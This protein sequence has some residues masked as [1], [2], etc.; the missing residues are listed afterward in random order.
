MKEIDL[1]TTTERRFEIGA[2]EGA[3]PRLDHHEI[4]ILRSDIWMKRRAMGAERQCPGLV[5]V[6]ED[7]R[8]F[9]LVHVSRGEADLDHGALLRSGI[10][11]I[12]SLGMCDEAAW[13][14]NKPFAQKPP[15]TCY[16]QALKF[17]V[18]FFGLQTQTLDEMRSCLAAGFHHPFRSSDGSGL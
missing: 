11:S 1:I 7:R 8:A 6:A 2:I 4:G 13:P 18:T 17:T 9:R 5:G 15:Q 12:A 14:Y 16:D 10:K 3:N